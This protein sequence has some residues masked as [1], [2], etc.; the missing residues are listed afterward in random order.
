MYKLV[1]TIKQGDTIAD[2]YE[3]PFGIRTIHF[4]VDKGFFLNGQHVEIKGTCNHQ[5]FAGVGVA[6]PDSIEE[7][8]VRKLKEMGANAWRMS[9]NP[10][11]PELL[12]DC[13]RMGMLVMDENRRMDDTPDTLDQ[14]RGSDSGATA[15]IP[16]SSSGPSATRKTPSKGPTTAQPSP[17]RCKTSS[18]NSTPA[19]SALSP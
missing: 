2:I 18:T 5:D 11:N 6:V 12:D 4:D 10:P 13:D 3:T 16:A 17:P 7:F 8:R 19:D 15:I 1:T 14:L 9:H